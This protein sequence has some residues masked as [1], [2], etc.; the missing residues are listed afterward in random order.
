MERQADKC[1]DGQTNRGDIIHLFQ[2]TLKK[3]KKKSHPLMFAASL[4]SK[5]LSAATME[6]LSKTNLTGNQ[7]SDAFQQNVTIYL[8]L[9]FSI[10]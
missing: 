3:K 4:H 7:N 5:H 6:R 9:T 1:I 8:S 2:Q 10:M